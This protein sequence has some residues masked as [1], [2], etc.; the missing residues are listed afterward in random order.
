MFENIETFLLQNTGI[1]WATIIFFAFLES[2]ILTGLFFSSILLFSVCVFIYSADLM[3]LYLIVIFAITGAHLGDMS[4]FFFGRS[5]GSKIL[6]KKF[7]LKRKKAIKRAQNFADKTKSFTVLIGRFIPAIRPIV[8]FLLGISS[9][10]PVRFYLA[11]LIACLVW[12]IA[13]GFLVT[14]MGKAIG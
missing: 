11:D 2:F 13:L 5:V 9:L 4:G 14:G 10:N 3:P 7:F 6:S 1:A 12:G 8:P